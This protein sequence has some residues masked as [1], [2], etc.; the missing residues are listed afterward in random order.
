MKSYTTGQVA[1]I[2]GVSTVTVRNEIERGNLVAFK[3]GIENR[4][5]QQRLDEYMGISNSWEK[6]REDLLKTIEEQKKIINKVR[7]F[8]RELEVS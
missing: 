5:T 3:V 1:E 6:E 7:S 8:I 4:I 2:L